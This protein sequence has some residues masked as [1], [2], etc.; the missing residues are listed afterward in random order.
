MKRY[1]IINTLIKNRGY[2]S[3][4]E[5][6]LC[7]GQ[8][9][10]EV[11]I[12]EKTSVDPAVHE[13]AHAKPT[14]QMTSDEFF[15]SNTDTFDI[16]FIDGLHHSD[17]VYRDIRNSLDALNEG[18]VVVCHDMNPQ[19]KEQQIVPRQQKTWTG[20]CWKALVK[21][22]TE[23]LPYRVRVVDTDWGVG[24]IENS[25]NPDSLSVPEDLTFENLQKNRKKWLN[26]ISIKE[27]VN[28]YAK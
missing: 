10:N 27:F 9:F 18:G 3:Y 13:Y 19:K 25:D 14:H 22:R 21:F 17:Q 23:H 8:T 5:I 26:L 15:D 6:G 7:Q 28:A 2:S 12:E 20:D 1:D 16:V 24:I 11:K 4:L